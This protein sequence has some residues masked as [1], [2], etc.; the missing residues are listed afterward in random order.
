MESSLPFPSACLSHWHR[1]TRSFPHLN[2]NHHAQVPITT[3][4]AIIGSGISGALTAFSLIENGTNPT[5][6]LILEAREAVSGA[7]GRN[8]GHIRPGKHRQQP[9]LHKSNLQLKKTPSAASPTTP[10]S[11]AQNKQSKSYKT[12]S[13]S[14]NK[15]APSSQPTT[16][17]PTSSTPPRSTYA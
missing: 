7:S 12:K 10:P 5:D 17:T 2:A 8:A 14:S 9:Q 4:H 16:S 3:K 13:A 6:I 15:P 11:T 1:G